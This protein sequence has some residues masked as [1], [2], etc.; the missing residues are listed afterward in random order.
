MAECSARRNRNPAVSGSSPALATYR[1]IFV[2]GGLEFKSSAKLVNSQLV[3]SCQLGFLIL[4]D[5]V[6]DF[7]I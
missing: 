1:I 3:A 5:V 4:P 7:N 6:F 2:V